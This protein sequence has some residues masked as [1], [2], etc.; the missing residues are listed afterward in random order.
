MNSL[1]L[2]R[3]GQPI[4]E[5]TVP[6]LDGRSRHHLSDEP[7]R[8]RLGQCCDGELILVAENRADSPQG[9]QD[10]DD[11]KADVF[12]YI[13]RFYNPRRRHLT[14]EYM[15]PVEFEEKAMLA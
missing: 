1:L 11:A 9:L 2:Q 10:R 14:L 8:Q 12:D 3:P 15:S 7:V 5:R 4:Y 6:A 13:E